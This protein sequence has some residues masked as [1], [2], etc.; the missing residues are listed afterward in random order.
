M[1]SP[2][3]GDLTRAVLHGG[4]AESATSTNS[5]IPALKIV[6]NPR[7]PGEHHNTVAFKEAVKDILQ[8]NDLWNTIS[9]P[10]RRRGS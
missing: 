7:N 6:Y 5:A 1:Q 9:E 10:C 2:P 4:G 8:A 3:N